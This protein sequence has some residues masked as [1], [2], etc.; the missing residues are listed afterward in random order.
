MEA[1]FTKKHM[2]GTKGNEY[3]IHQKRLFE[4]TKKYFTARTVKHSV[5][6]KHSGALIIRA[7]RY[8]AEKGNR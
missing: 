3:R 7:C 1:L 8:T 5:T 6:V 4:T 2:E